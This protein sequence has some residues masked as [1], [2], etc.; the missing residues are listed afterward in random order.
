MLIRPR[1]HKEWHQIMSSGRC[2]FYED[3]C[4]VRLD[5]VHAL[6]RDEYFC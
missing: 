2:A 3:V 6:L 1:A 4:Q 5:S